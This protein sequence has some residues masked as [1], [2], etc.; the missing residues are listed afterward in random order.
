M[1]HEYDL[2]VERQ[3]ATNTVVSVSYIGSLGRRLPRFV[4][5]NLAP[6]NLTTTY[7]VTQGAGTVT[8]PFVDQ[9]FIGQ[10][11]T[12][13]YFGMQADATGKKPLSGG[14]GRPNTA[15]GTITNIS[16]SVNSNYNALVVALNRRFYRSFQIQA[17]YTFSHSLDAG[18]SSQ[19][20]TAAN[21]VL[22]PF[23]LGA[24]YSRS[25]FDIRHRFSFGAVWSPEPYKGENAVLRQAV[26]GFTI[27]P[28]VTISSGVPFTPTISGNAPSQTDNG[29]TFID[30]STGVLGVGGTNRP[31]FFTANSF[32]LPRTAIVDL[33]LEKS[34]KVWENMKFTLIGDAFNL[35]NHTNF[36]SADTQMYTVSGTNLAFNPHF[37]V[38]TQS[39][40]SLIGQRQIQIGARFNF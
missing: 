22:N 17:N 7:T 39:S 29:V 20:F 15:F 37:G 28:L 13:P 2:E 38:P 6:A 14:T 34:F 24:E 36:T 11:F 33:R 40:N 9:A 12:V 31:P 1:V 23:D 3:I 26:N 16:G 8:S 32:Q 30:V 5:T 4:D 25:N 19:T 10:T 21:N 35:F 27:S 18:Q